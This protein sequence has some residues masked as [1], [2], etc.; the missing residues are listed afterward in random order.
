[1]K[2]LKLLAT[3]TFERV[4]YIENK[5]N[6]SVVQGNTYIGINKIEDLDILKNDEFIK[7]YTHIAC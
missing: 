5:I 7:F 3:V 4:Y 2:S 1:M 6:N